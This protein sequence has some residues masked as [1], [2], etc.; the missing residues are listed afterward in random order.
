VAEGRALPT[1]APGEGGVCYSRKTE[2]RSK[3]GYFSAA[4]KFFSETLIIFFD[5]NYLSAKI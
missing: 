3:K 2:Q 4:Y 5:I 1:E